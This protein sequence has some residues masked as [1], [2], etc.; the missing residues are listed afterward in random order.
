M[1]GGWSVKGVGKR[2]LAVTLAA[3]CALAGLGLTGCGGVKGKHALMESSGS[4]AL[5]AGDAALTR[6][7]RNEAGRQYLIALKKGGDP[8]KAHTRLGDLYLSSGMA[9]DKARFEYEQALKADAKFAPAVQG[10]GFALF[11]GGAPNK[12]ASVLRQALDL[13]PGLSRAAALLGTI[14]NRQGHPAEALAVFDKS[15]AVAF[16]PDVENNRGLSLLLLG[17]PEEA[18]AAFRRALAAKKT[19]KIANN[20]GLAL[21]RMKRYDEAYAVFASVGSQAAALNNVGVC[22]MEAG[23]KAQAQQYFERAI[24]TNPSYYE[25]AQSNLNRLSASEMVNLPFA[26]PAAPAPAG[27]APAKPAPAA[28]PSPAATAPAKPVPATV[29]PP[30]RAR[31]AAARNAATSEKADRAE[32]P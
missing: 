25:K 31:S 29:T 28:V 3:V 13:D 14:E 7:D 24:A 30:S 6:G 4:A 27:Q 1:E 2:V 18:V 9:I 23:D 15:L 17:R 10:L 8:A 19:A 16:D 26:A 20:L 11:L 12:A 21:C 32:M 5:A 22:Y